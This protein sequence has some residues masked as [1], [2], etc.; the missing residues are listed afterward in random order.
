MADETSEI[1]KKI[2][3]DLLKNEPIE[4]VQLAY[5]YAKNYTKYGVNVIEDWVTA[6][7]QSYALE[8]AYLKGVYDC[9]QK[10]EGVNKK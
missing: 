6:T 8:Q 9:Q 10:L 2:L 7:K 3:L 5:L 4:V 1:K